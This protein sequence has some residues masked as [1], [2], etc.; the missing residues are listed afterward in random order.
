MA[1]GIGTGRKPSWKA[2]FD[3]EQPVDAHGL[4]RRH[5]RRSKYVVGEEVISDAEMCQRS[6]EVVDVPID[7]RLIAPLYG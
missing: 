5:R 2:R 1:P 4:R 6:P 3:T 7:F